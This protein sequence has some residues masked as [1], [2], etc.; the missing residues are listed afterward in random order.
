MDVHFQGTLRDPLDVP[1]PDHPIRVTAL[2]TDQTIKGSTV[3]FMTDENGAYDF[4]LLKGYYSLEVM[5]T[6]GDEFLLTGKLLLNQSTPQSITLEEGLMYSTRVYPDD[7]VTIDEPWLTWWNTLVEESLT[8]TREYLVQINNC[9][10]HS[11]DNHQTWESEDCSEQGVQRTNEVKAGTARVQHQERVYSDEFASTGSIKETSNASIKTDTDVGT[12][13]SDVETKTTITS[14][15]TDT[16]Q[17]GTTV[18]RQEQASTVS[19]SLTKLKELASAIKESLVLNFGSNSVVKNSEL[20]N[21]S[22]ESYVSTIGSKQTST[23]HTNNGTNSAYE[24]V[25]DNLKVSKTSA[26]PVL[27]VD[28]STGKVTV[29]GQLQIG[30]LLDENGDPID[31]TPPEDGDTI[32]QVYQYSDSNLGPWEDEVQPYHYW[33]RENFSI[34]GLVDPNTW[35]LPY[36]FRGFDGTDGNSGDTV[37]IEY[38]YSPD[39]VVWHPEPFVSGDKFR[40]ERVVT[41]GVAG[42]WSDPGR[43]VGDDGETIETRSEYSIDGIYNWHAVLDPA[44]RWERRAVFVN[45]VQDGP[46]SDPFPIGRGE[47]GEDGTS[48]FKSVVFKRQETQP[49]TPTGGSWDNPIPSGWSDGVPAGELQLWASTRVFDEE[50]GGLALWTTPQAMTDTETLDFEYSVTGIGDPTSDPSEWFNTPTP[51]SV[52]MAQRTKKNG[53]WTDW[54]ITKIKGEDGESGDTIYEESRYGPTQTIDGNWTDWDGTQL[55][56]HFWRQDRI[57][58]NGVPGSPSVVYRIVGKPGSGWYTI[59]NGTGNFPSDA[60]ATVDFINNFGRTPVLDDHL[61][62]VDNAN[63][64]LV[65]N[66]EVKRC[67]SP[68]GSPVTWSDPALVIQGDLIVRGTISGDRLVANTITGNQISSATTIIAGSGSWTAG[69]NGDDTASANDYR[70]WRFWAG[71]SDPD[72]APFRVDRNGKLWATDADISGTVTATSGSFTGDIYAETLTLSGSGAQI[73]SDNYVEGLQGWSINND[74]TA[75]FFNGTFRGTIFAEEI[76]GDLVSATITTYTE[77]SVGLANGWRDVPD[78]SF[79][80]INNTGDSASLL[81]RGPYLTVTSGSAASGGYDITLGFR[82]VKNGVP[83]TG[84]ENTIR[85]NN[86]WIGGGGAAI[87]MRI[88]LYHVCHDILVPLLNIS[89]SDTYKLQY[90]A[91]GTTS[92]VSGRTVTIKGN[93]LGNMFRNGGAFS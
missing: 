13:I 14:T 79:N 59:N 44:D 18:S 62:Y 39:G 56:T 64:A 52:W 43:I 9:G 45:G 53:I 26:S 30:S 66:S 27:T 12:E 93:T 63:A 74:G 10:S 6:E 47:Q 19:G 46:W 4:Y 50:L 41:N 21:S 89:N 22:E 28:T 87:N 34:N 61:T 70:Y 68:E 32:Y 35:S 82:L 54:V 86:G 16:D 29:N 91:S 25:V 23:T 8:K 15:L 31:L 75:E 49:D 71:A 92:G 65:T 24:I 77:D 58:T 83:V 51:A 80:V 38:Q 48:R 11:V 73:Q 1:M 81:V 55:D 17:V 2:H 78:G 90:L 57:V 67:N 60:Q 3:T 33:R 7:T 20:S 85:Y 36:Q 69:M 88:S 76:I 5:N 42:D 72:F 40:R 37:Y 84:S